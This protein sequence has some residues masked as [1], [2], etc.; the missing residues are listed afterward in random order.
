MTKYG[1]ENKLP[2]DITSAGTPDAA[3]AD[4]KA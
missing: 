4:I 2:L 3:I 1:Q